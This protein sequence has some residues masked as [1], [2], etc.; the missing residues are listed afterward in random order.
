MAVETKVELRRA[1][2]HIHYIDFEPMAGETVEV[3][4]GAI[5]TAYTVVSRRW[6]CTLS[7]TRQRGVVERVLVC[8][9]E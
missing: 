2:K 1:G 4:D 6:Y 7:R 5:T 9:V 3:E 8:E